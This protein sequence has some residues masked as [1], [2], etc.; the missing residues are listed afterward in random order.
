MKNRFL[1]VRPPPPT[2]EEAGAPLQLPSAPT[3]APATEPNVAP[4]AS[5][6]ASGERLYTPAQQPAEPLEAARG[7][8][9]P[10]GGGRNPGPPDFT[11][12]L[13]GTPVEPQLGPVV[14]INQD[15][16]VM[17]G[18]DPVRT[19]EYENEALE[20]FE[21]DER[22]R[23]QDESE[24]LTPDQGRTATDAPPE[25]RGITTLHI[26]IRNRL[27]IY[28]GTIFRNVLGSK[29]FYTWVRKR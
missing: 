11:D 7:S 18:E 12:P 26:G 23:T 27:G 3:P 22:R 24:Q 25:W 20:D 13:E 4:P 19:F 2:T 9:T 15:N 6:P 14:H 1:V 10:R 16:V 8:R 5:D 29:T 17:Y 28:V 21:A